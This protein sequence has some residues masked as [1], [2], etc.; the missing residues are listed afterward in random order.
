MTTVPKHAI[1]E[2]KTLRCQVKVNW[3]SELVTDSNILVSVR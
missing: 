3:K 2:S 1:T